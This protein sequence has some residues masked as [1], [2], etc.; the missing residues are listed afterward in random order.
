LT[1]YPLD[2]ATTP[3]IL[4]SS[5]GKDLA[6]LKRATAIL[7]GFKETTI[8]LISKIINLYKKHYIYYDII[9]FTI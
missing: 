8:F 5:D 4:N 6:K 7:T 1:S 3:E 2:T 9:F